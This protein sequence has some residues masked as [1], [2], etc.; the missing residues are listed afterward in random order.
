MDHCVTSKPWSIVNEY[1]RSR[2]NNKSL[3]RN[4]L[5]S[6]SPAPKVQ[7]ISDMSSSIVDLTR[8]VRLISIAGIK[9]PRTFKVMGNKVLKCNHGKNL[10]IIFDKYGYE[11]SVPTKQGNVNQMERC[12]NSLDQDLPPIM[13][14][15]EFLM[16]Q[17]SELQIVNLL[18]E[19]IKWGAIA[20]KAIIVN[21]NSQCFFVSQTKPSVC[22]SPNQILCTGRL[23]KRSLCM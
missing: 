1:Q 17:K 2:G 16:N 13:E 19:Y 3:F 4:Y 18:V 23:I 11:Y 7:K 22:V 15:S 9:K 14:W 21:Q 8:V 20:D 10:H 12:I 5:Q 6:V